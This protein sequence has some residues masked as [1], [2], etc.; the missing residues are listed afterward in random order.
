MDCFVKRGPR[1]RSLSINTLGSQE[2]DSEYQIFHSENEFKNRL[3]LR[4]EIF[5]IN[6]SIYISFI[7]FNLSFMFSFFSPPITHRGNSYEELTRYTS[8]TRTVP[9]IGTI[10][11]S[12]PGYNFIFL[13]LSLSLFIWFFLLFSISL[14]LPQFSLSICL[15]F[16]SR[17]QHSTQIRPPEA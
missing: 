12:F 16:S 3:T 5:W 7:F 9:F 15:S 8:G 4:N 14:V 10:S 2:T 6:F 1:T 13:S 11:N 17:S